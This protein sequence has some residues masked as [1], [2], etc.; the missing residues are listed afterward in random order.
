[1]QQAGNSI[2]ANGF[3]EGGK[4]KKNRVE[5]IF[6]NLSKTCAKQPPRRDS[7]LSLGKQADLPRPAGL[8]GVSGRGCSRTSQYNQPSQAPGVTHPVLPQRA[9][10][11]APL[12]ATAVVLVQL[13]AQLNREPD[14]QPGNRLRATALCRGEAAKRGTSVGLWPSQRA[15]EEKANKRWCYTVPQGLLSCGN[16]SAVLKSA[17]AIKNQPGKGTLDC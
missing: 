2:F 8:Q 6:L 5:G 16:V 4:K 14:Q 11:P 7:V 10:K 1:M 17:H 15:A 9:W 3:T 13:L 12:P